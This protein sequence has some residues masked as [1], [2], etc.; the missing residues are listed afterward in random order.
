MNSQLPELIA[1]S[2]DMMKSDWK[3]PFKRTQRRSIGDLN[4]VIK[5][6]KRLSGARCAVLRLEPRQHDPFADAIWNDGRK[7]NATGLQN[8]KRALLA[9]VQTAM[10]A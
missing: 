10:A 2:T 7:A 6:S 3:E 9:F 1:P 5:G 4:I 8:T